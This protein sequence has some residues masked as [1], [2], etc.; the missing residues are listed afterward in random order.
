MN[1]AAPHIQSRQ[2]RDR[3]RQRAAS[4]RAG[5]DRVAAIYRDFEQGRSPT[6]CMRDI[7][8]VVKGRRHGSR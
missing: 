6:E 5:M 7:G 2:D 3:I 4:N 1:Q 8:R